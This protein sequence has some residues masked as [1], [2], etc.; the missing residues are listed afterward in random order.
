MVGVLEDG[1]DAPPEVGAAGRGVS[2]RWDQARDDGDI[3]L[4]H[5]MVSNLNRFIMT[6]SRRLAWE[7]TRGGDFHELTHRRT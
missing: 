5:R 7:E 6:S 1:V 4:E 3:G 2:Y